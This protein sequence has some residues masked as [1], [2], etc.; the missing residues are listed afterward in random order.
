[1]Y[2]S[3][4]SFPL[5][6]WSILCSHESLYL[7][8][9]ATASRETQACNTSKSFLKISFLFLFFFLFFLN[10]FLFLQAKIQLIPAM[11][12]HGL[13]TASCLLSV[14]HSAPQL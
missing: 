7:L 11:G 6:F 4:L 8:Q 9:P 2:A 14:S 12:S 10:G 13:R 5:F 1:M 3:L